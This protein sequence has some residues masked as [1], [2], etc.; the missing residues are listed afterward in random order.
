MAE[1][2]VT[3]RPAPVAPCACPSCERRRENDARVRQIIEP[4]LPTAPAPVREP[5]KGKFNG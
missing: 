4:T 5:R 3:D 2:T 1:G